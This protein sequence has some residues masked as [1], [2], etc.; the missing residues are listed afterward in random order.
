MA[1]VKK[2][3]LLNGKTYGSNV[4]SGQSKKIRQTKISPMQLPPNNLSTSSPSLF[5]DSGMNSPVVLKPRK[6]IYS[7]AFNKPQKS[8]SPPVVEKIKLKEKSPIKMYEIEKSAAVEKPKYPIVKPRVEQQPRKSDDKEN[9]S[10]VA[11]KWKSQ[12][13]NVKP[14]IEKDQE[15]NKLVEKLVVKLKPEAERPQPIRSFVDQ[16]H[17]QHSRKIVSDDSLSEP[18]SPDSAA[19]SV[20][21]VKDLLSG[22][23]GEF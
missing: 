15:P 13:E 1:I 6:P 4:K 23:L 8:I 12:V 16:K 7:E 2:T 9:P 19:E 3:T 17:Q 22:F 20:M 18:D 5:D 10:V 21:H 11:D 14:K